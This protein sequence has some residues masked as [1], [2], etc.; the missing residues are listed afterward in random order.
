MVDL[1]SSITAIAN[2]DG[3]VLV[4][5]NMLLSNDY[6]ASGETIVKFIR[7]ALLRRTKWIECVISNGCTAS[8]AFGQHVAK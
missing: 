1:R 4:G 3:D 6:A 5:M 8:S 2:A 7:G